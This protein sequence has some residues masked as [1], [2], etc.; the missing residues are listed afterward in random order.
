[1][2]SSLLWERGEWARSTV[3][4][5]HVWGVRLAGTSAGDFTGW[6]IISDASGRQHRN[7]YLVGINDGREIAPRYRLWAEENIHCAE[8]LLVLGWE[9][10]VCRRGRRGCRH[11]T[12][13]WAGSI[14][15]RVDVQ[16][17]AKNPSCEHKLLRPASFTRKV[18]IRS[19]PCFL[20]SLRPSRAST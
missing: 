16:Q 7:E 17:R 10:G 14:R 5:T 15:N 12:N 11:R 20:T 1:M 2:K 9:I 13:G 4:E 3:P 18:L 19:L 6:Q 8:S